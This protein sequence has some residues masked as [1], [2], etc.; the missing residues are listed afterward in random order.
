MYK[1][2][3]AEDESL[4]RKAINIII[5][6]HFDNIEVVE[7]AKNGL[8]AVRIAKKTKPDIIIM[9][10]KMPE[11]GGIEAQKEILQFHPT[12]KTVILTA[13]DE[14][15][16]A[17]S[18]I[19]LN[20][21][22]YLLKPARPLELVEAIN[23]AISHIQFNKELK[24]EEINLINKSLIEKAVSYIHKN[25]S[26]NINLESV[27]SYVHLN[28]QYFSRYF[29]ANVGMTFIDYVSKLRIKRAKELLTSTDDSIGEISFKVGYIDPGYFSKVFSRHEGVSPHKFRMDHKTSNMR[30]NHID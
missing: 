13:Y 1:L 23:R 26:G 22:D 8:E 19:K 5:K 21:V 30:I 17:H 18:A 20:V 29:K 27:A 2:M 11:K 15:Q 4:E 24:D 3:I 7:E 28:P 14:F 9:D 6:K 10:I 16:F 25:Y 12:V